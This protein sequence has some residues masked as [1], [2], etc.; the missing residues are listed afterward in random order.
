MERVCVLSSFIVEQL[1]VNTEPKGAIF[2]FHPHYEGCL[3]A[4]VFPDDTIFQHG[5]YFCLYSLI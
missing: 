1:V 3:W 2:L 5:L 4:E